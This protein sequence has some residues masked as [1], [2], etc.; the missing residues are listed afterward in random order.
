MPTMPTRRL[1]RAQFLGW[2]AMLPFAS[3]ATSMLRLLRVRDRAEPVPVPADVP[4]GL[5]LSGEVVLNRGADG[6]LRAFAARCTHLGCRLDRVVDG[7]VAC[8]C[9]GS[10]FHA[11][12]R[13]A[14]GPAARPLTELRV[15]PDAASGGWTIDGT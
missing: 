11:D 1:P 6:S 3:A 13:V 4:L 12:G 15:R 8:P 2:L 5:S 10:R 14:A 7:M 9:H